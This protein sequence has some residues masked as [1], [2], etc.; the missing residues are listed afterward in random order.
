MANSPLERPHG[1]VTKAQARRT[2]MLRAATEA[3]LN[4]GFETTTLDDVIG[5]SGG[6]RATL[7]REF[8]DKEGLFAAIVAEL[9]ARVA[10]PLEISDGSARASLLAL[11][12]AYMTVLMAPENIGLYRLVVAEGR[13]F[14]KLAE[15]VFA[16]GPE[17]LTRR[18]AR[19]LGSE[20]KARIFCEMVKGDLHTRALFGVD[21]PSSREIDATVREAVRIFCDGL[22]LR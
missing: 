19:V 14:P 11:A 21:V 1:K 13:R 22:A 8:G 9:C 4:G 5:R 2:A 15:K 17:A 16:A 3:F 7:Y 10:E 12:R 20:R 6:S 18:L